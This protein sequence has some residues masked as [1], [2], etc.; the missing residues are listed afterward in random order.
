[1]DGM[2][3]AIRGGRF[4]LTDL[5]DDV[6]A[7]RIPDDQ[8]WRAVSDGDGGRKILEIWPMEVVFKNLAIEAAHFLRSTAARGP[9]PQ[10]LSSDIRTW[11]R[12]TRKL[13]ARLPVAAPTRAAM[14]AAAESADVVTGWPE[15]YFTIGPD[16]K[17]T[18]RDLAAGALLWAIQELQTATKNAAR[19]YTDESA[20]D[21]EHPW[22]ALF[23][24]GDTPSGMHVKIIDVEDDALRRRVDRVRTMIKPGMADALLADTLRDVL[25]MGVLLPDG[26]KRAQTTRQTQ[27]SNIA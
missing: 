5:P 20:P 25:T 12:R 14:L 27:K 19:R 4:R 3:L 9:S 17:M 2:E 7:I 24:E 23:H 1:M 10:A 18:F 22:P 15:R 21:Y 8:L 6:R 26:S 16:A 13:A 11:I